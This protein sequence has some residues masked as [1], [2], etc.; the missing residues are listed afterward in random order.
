V[1]AIT[2]VEAAN[3]GALMA[4]LQAQRPLMVYHDDIYSS[5]DGLDVVDE[6]ARERLLNDGWIVCD[7]GG[8]YGVEGDGNWSAEPP[9]RQ[10]WG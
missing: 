6:L 3:A 2:V 9:A 8:R 7:V 10:V 1:S 4:S 5:A